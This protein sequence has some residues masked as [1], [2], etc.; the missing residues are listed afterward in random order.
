MPD[1]VPDLP[2]IESLDNKALDGSIHSETISPTIREN[3]VKALELLGL[4]E[5]NEM[6]KQGLPFKLIGERVTNELLNDFENPEIEGLAYR[7]DRS[8]FVLDESYTGWYKK[9]SYWGE[10]GAGLYVH[11]DKKGLDAYIE[12]IQKQAVPHVTALRID[13]G[14]YFDATNEAEGWDHQLL[15]TN[16][17]IDSYINSVDKWLDLSRQNEGVISHQGKRIRGTSF[18]YFEAVKAFMDSQRDLTIDERFQTTFKGLK[19]MALNLPCPIVE[20]EEG[21]YAHLDDAAFSRNEHFGGVYFTE[22]EIFALFLQELGYD[23]TY[24]SF[25]KIT[26]V[27]VTWNLQKIGTKED[28]TRRIGVE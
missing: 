10:Q 26:P 15:L 23:G 6:D 8:P 22:I 19:S 12:Y 3:P 21:A 28:W 16:S 13:S 9:D 20:R 5:V 18:E 24:F 25:N 14:R 11:F 7:V 27:A 4:T 1:Q 2:P 17:V